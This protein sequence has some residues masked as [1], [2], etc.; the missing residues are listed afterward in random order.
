[1]IEDIEKGLI[2]CVIVKD[3]SRL[4][5]NYIET[6]QYTELYFPE[7]NVRFIAVNDGVDSNNGDN[8]FAPFKNII[9]EWYA[10]DVSKKVRA[11]IEA[12]HA[13]GERLST[14]AV[15]G[16]KKHP[17]EKGKI[18][19]DEDTKWIVEKIFKYALEGKGISH[20]TRKL[21]QEKIPTPSYFHYKRDGYFSYLYD[22]E[23]RE[24]KKYE[25]GEAQV[26]KILKDET[27]IGN[28][29]Y[30]KQK[31]I[32]YK[33]KKRINNPKS[34]WKVIKGTH[35]PIIDEKDFF[36]VQKMI[37]S[38]HRP[39]KN[40]YEHIFSGLIKCS[41]CGRTMRLGQVKKYGKSYKYFVCNRYSQMGKQFCSSHYISY[42]SLYNFVLSRVI[43]W[44]SRAKID[45]KGLFLAI[46]AQKNKTTILSTDRTKNDIEKLKKRLKE[47]ENIIANLYEDK[48]NKKISEKNFNMLMKKYEQEQND[49]QKKI[50]ILAQ[51]LK[52]IIDDLNDKEKWINILKEITNPTELSSEMVHN[53]IDKIIIHESTVAEDGIKEQEIEIY[54]KFVGNI[55]VIP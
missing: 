53:L 45:S 39:P 3:L 35:E 55:D 9:N 51:E 11:G 49:I 33:T 24:S 22:G 14:Y 36:E 48:I 15:F 43:F 54:Y 17:H 34:E 7:H 38:R 20:I 6:G 46:N 30:N 13:M 32:S 52:N 40:S 31:S 37:S 28:T 16:Y 21:I 44:V 25:W 10:K 50:N 1:M 47:I 18:I 29:V 5:R 41:D 2:N 12:K 42:N 26:K 4:G 8:E 19:I 23:Q 27:Y